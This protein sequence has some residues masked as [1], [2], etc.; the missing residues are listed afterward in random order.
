MVEDA[1][2]AVRN[3]FALTMTYDSLEHRANVRQD[4]GVAMGGM[5]SVSYKRVKDDAGNEVTSCLRGRRRTCGRYTSA[6][7]R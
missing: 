3:G 4:S 2:P 5:F 1:D 6:P 7:S